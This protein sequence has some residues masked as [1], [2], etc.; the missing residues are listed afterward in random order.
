MREPDHEARRDRRE[1]EREAG[2]AFTQVLRERLEAGRIP[3]EGREKSDE[4]PED[5]GGWQLSRSV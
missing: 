2:V 1:R 3:L 4:S 5:G